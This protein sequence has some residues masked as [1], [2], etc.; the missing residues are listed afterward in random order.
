EAGSAPALGREQ[1]VVLLRAAQEALS[2]VR[3]HAAAQHVQLVLGGSADQVHLEVVDDGRGIDP[4]VRTGFGLRGMRDRVTSGG[5]ELAVS[6]GV[7]GG[8]RVRVT[9]PAEDAT[10]PPTAA[11]GR[12]TT[13]ECS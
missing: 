13:L 10:V 8:T 6:N 12:P 4:D 2:N 5:G 3:R 7:S 9:L 11:D 1:E